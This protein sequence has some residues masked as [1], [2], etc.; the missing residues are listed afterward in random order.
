MGGEG[1][2]MISTSSLPNIIITDTAISPFKVAIKAEEHPFMTYN[3][4]NCLASSSFGH[5][6]YIRECAMETYS[7]S[8]IDGLSA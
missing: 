3:P 4:T 6:Q 7:S 5:L 1:G 2:N 8:A